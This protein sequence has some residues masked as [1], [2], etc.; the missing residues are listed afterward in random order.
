MSLGLKNKVA[1][2][3][4][5]SVG[6]GSS[7]AHGLAAHGAQIAKDNTP[8]RSI[9]IL[10]GNHSLLC[11]PLLGKNSISSDPHINLTVAG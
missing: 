4:G 5:G 9:C 2:I 11:L 7:I 10:S 3:T 6:M 1:L 8:H